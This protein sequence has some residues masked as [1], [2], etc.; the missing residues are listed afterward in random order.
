LIRRRNGGGGFW[1]PLHRLAKVSRYVKALEGAHA[2]YIL[3]ALSIIKTGTPNDI[4]RII[5]QA[6]NSET[7]LHGGSLLN[8]L[9]I[10]TQQG[11]LTYTKKG[12]TKH[13]KLT[14]AGQTLAR[15]V[16]R[17][18]DALCEEVECEG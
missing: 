4:T 14:T 17:L 2:T 3:V 11:F 18:V 16:K 6:T 1:L 9:K 8:R 12:R 13:Y 5:A 15:A 7:I 10:L